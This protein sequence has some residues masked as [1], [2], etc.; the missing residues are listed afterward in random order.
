MKRKFQGSV[1]AYLIAVII[2]LVVG[3]KLLIDSADFWA[4]FWAGITGQPT[5]HPEQETLVKT[6]I[7]VIL[8]IILLTVFFSLKKRIS[9]PVRKIYDGMKR[10]ESGDLDAEIEASDGFEFKKMEEGFN[11]MVRGLREARDYQEEMA[12]K[13][14]ELYAE[15]AHDLKTPMT[16]ILGYA[17]LL[18]AGDVPEDKQK[19]YLCT[20]TEQTEN[21]NSLLEQMLEYAKLGSTEYKLDY[22]KH[23]LAECLRLA[24]S[25]SYLRFEEKG[26]SLDID[27]TEDPV[28]IEYDERQIK[29]VIYNLIGNVINH[30]PEGTAVDVSMKVGDLHV[31]GNDKATHVTSET[32]MTSATKATYA[33]TSSN[34]LVQIIIADNG[35]LIAPE[36]KDFLFDPFKTGDESRSKSGSGLGLS[37]AKKIV[38]LHNGTLEYQ[39]SVKP[40][41]KGFVIT[42]PV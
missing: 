19:E 38:E 33:T 40:G 16:M 27:I 11:S 3:I 9:K 35:P 1:L 7:Y 30:N 28:E 20:I 14:R 4:G 5:A 41:Y 25:D 8:G 24:V 12:E 37:V 2:A 10:V 26:M 34:H 39:E 18:A 22:K 15:I 21:A 17:K 31:S 32:D 13:N 23:D 42:L 36:L 29:R 6:I